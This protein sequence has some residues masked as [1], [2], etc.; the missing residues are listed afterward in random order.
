[1][2]ELKIGAKTTDRAPEYS[3]KLQRKTVSDSGTNLFGYRARMQERLSARLHQV[4]DPCA[5]NK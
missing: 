3:D 2:P 5:V 1:M 4:T